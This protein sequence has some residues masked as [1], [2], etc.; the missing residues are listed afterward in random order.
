MGVNRERIVGVGREYQH[1][2]SGLMPDPGKVYRPMMKGRFPGTA[3]SSA[4]YVAFRI[5][6]P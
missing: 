4:W 2:G 3:R 1:A 5:R 6:C